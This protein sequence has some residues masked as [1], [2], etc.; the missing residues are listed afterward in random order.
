MI[1]VT[2]ITDY[3]AAA[4]FAGDWAQSFKVLS[5]KKTSKVYRG[6]TFRPGMELFMGEN[7]F[8]G[9]NAV[10]LV[11]YLQMDDG[12]Q[13]NAGAILFGREAVR[14]GKNSVISYNAVIGTSTDTLRGNYMNDA[15]PENQRC[16]KVAPVKIGD[17]CFIGANCVI[18]PGVKIGSNSVI[19]AGSYIDRDIPA[20]TVVIPKQEL[21]LKERERL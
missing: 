14:I 7:T 11:P 18:M 5:V 16:I 10:V 13:I 15:S 6:A 20:N 12:S 17:N 9:T 19:G 4:D 2:P 8:I 21:L 3:W 1:I